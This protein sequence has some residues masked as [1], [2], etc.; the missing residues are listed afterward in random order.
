MYRAINRQSARARANVTAVFAF[1]AM[2]LV[3]SPV[4][5]AE[6]RGVYWDPTVDGEGWTFDSQQDIS[7]AT[8]YRY[9]NGNPSFRTVIAETDYS[10]V[11]E[12][13]GD[14]ILQVI[15][16]RVFRTANGQTVDE[17]PF[18]AVF[19]TVAGITIGQVNAAGTVRNLIP[20]VYG[21]ENIVDL[22]RGLWT[23]SSFPSESTPSGATLLL[24]DPITYRFDDGV[25]Y[26]EF[27]TF[28]QREGF[29]YLDAERRSVI[30]AIFNSDGSYVAFAIEASN[31]SVIG[32]GQRFS[33]SNSALS[34]VFLITASAMTTSDKE[35]VAILQRAGLSRPAKTRATRGKDDFMRVREA[36]KSS[37]LFQ[38]K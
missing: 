8:W 5:Q 29:L 32:S 23:L 20:F 21:Y 19:T 17:G 1:V 33:P 24:F 35:V 16:G 11:Q 36:L 28:D 22:Y 15:Q 6:V 12:Q 9:D 26:R 31:V 27:L 37:V 30:G 34:P 18:T 14:G 38:G 10:V 4:T 3:F 25:A 2:I 13:G 7:I